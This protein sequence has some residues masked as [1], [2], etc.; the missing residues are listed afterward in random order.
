MTNSI[1][2][3]WRLLRFDAKNVVT[4][5]VYQLYGPDPVGTL[6]LSEDGYMSVAIMARNRTDFPV[7]SLQGASTEAKAHACETYLS[8]SGRWRIEDTKIFVHVLVSLLPNW[9]NKEHYR[10]FHLEA[11]TLTFQTP[12][13]QTGGSE[14]VIELSWA[15]MS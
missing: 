4:N 5:K 10:R 15:R 3:A 2:G 9:T 11:D 6:L 12:I 1:I 7:E 13:L 14:T 8:Y